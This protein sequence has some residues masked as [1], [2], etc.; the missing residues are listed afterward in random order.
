[1]IRTLSRRNVAIVTAFATALDSKVIHLGHA[2]PVVGLVAE[3]AVS[4]G[5]YMVGRGTGCPYVPRSRVAT[6]A[7]PWCPGEHR[8]HMATLAVDLGMAKIQWKGCLVMIEVLLCM[9]RSP[10]AQ[11]QQKR[12]QQPL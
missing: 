3:L 6:A 4:C 7:L 8:I 2:L 11:Y 5:P 1:M 12:Q 10:S 9:S